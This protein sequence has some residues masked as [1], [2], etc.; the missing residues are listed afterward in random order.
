MINEEPV[1][2]DPQLQDK[3]ENLKNFL[4]QIDSAIIAFSG[5]V[6]STLLLKVAK[7]AIG[8]DV[9]AVTSSSE[10]IP[11]RELKKARDLAASIGVEHEVIYTKE[12]QVESFRTNPPDR[13]YYCKRELFT[14][15]WEI[16]NKRNISAVFDGSNYDDIGDH[17]PGL[18][19]AS[20]LQ[21]SS[22][23]QEAGLTKQEVRKLSKFFK[24][25]TWNKPAMACLSSRFPYGEELSKEKIERVEQGEDLLEE[26]GFSQFRLR[27]H[28]EMARLE[29]LP[30]EFDKL[31]SNREQVLNKLIDLGFN[32]VTLDLAGYRSGSMNDEL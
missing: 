25:P 31:L 22:P 32:R 28:G 16:A 18:K 4:S 17:R 5:G 2:L 23:L 19:A 1:T 12:L 7:D 20:S 9:L 3:Y 8:G 14:D 30:E 27:Y 21:V 29:L 6:D 13:C 15:L 26:L 11:E 10:T 24:L